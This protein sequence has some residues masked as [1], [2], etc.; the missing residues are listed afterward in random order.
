MLINS[1]TVETT[2]STELRSIEQ[3]LATC[4]VP[5]HRE[6]SAV[7]QERSP[8]T[9]TPLCSTPTLKS[10]NMPNKDVSKK[11]VVELLPAHQPLQTI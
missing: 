2:S 9:K 3:H 8:S 1:A 11:S 7:D 6:P 5:A 10:V 4:N